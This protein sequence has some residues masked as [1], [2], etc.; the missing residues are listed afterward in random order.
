MTIELRQTLCQQAKATAQCLR[1]HRQA[2]GLKYIPSQV[3][4]AVQ[5]ALRVL[6]HW[7][8][9]DPDAHDPFIEMCRFAITLSQKF[10]AVAD[11][12][13]HIQSLS[14]SGGVSLPVEAISILDGSE[15]RRAQES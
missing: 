6:V 12:I 5:A 15:S 11:T 7:L 9:D 4:D 3:V 13:H 14:R 10:R 1:V 8:K 2:Y